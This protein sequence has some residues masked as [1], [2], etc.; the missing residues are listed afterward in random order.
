[1]VMG[2]PLSATSSI[3]ARHRALKA[4]ALIF[5]SMLRFLCDYMI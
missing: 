4:A 3:R 1:M 5:L 2:W